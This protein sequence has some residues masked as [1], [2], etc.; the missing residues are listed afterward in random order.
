MKTIISIFTLLLLL[1][2]QGAIAQS[3]NFKDTVKLHS[4]NVWA[5]RKIE[6]IGVTRTKIDSVALHESI[7]NTLS[8]VLSQNTTI[9]IKNYGR[10]SMATASFRGTAPS[11]TQVTWNGMK[12]NSPMLGMVDFSLIPSYFVDD[13]TLL[14]G[15]GSVDVGDGALGGAIVLNNKHIKQ[16]ETIHIIQGIANYDTYDSYLRYNYGTKKLKLTTRVYNVTSVNKFPFYNM[17]KNL[18]FKTDAKGNK[19]KSVEGAPTDYNQNGKYRNTHLLQ[20]AYYKLNNN[21]HFSFVT[22]AYQS[23]RSIPTLSVNWDNDLK[24][25]TNSQ[26]D[27]NIRSVASWKWINEKFNM[28]TR[29]GY[30]YNELNYSLINKTTTGHNAAIDSK[31]SINNIYTEFNANYEITKDFK[32]TAKLNY[33]LFNVDTY[34]KQ[35]H[36]GY[37]KYRAEVSPYLALRYKAFGIWGISYNVRKTINNDVNSPLIH[38]ILTDLLIWK[39]YNLIIKSSAVKNY[40]APTLNDLYFQPGGNPDLLTEE[41]TTYDCGIEFQR[42][43]RNN[44]I[45]GSA[46]YYHSDINNWIIWTPTFKGYWVPKN[47]RKVISNGI[48]LKLTTSKKIGDF[49]LFIDA[50]WGKTISTNHG[51]KKTWGDESVGKQL[52]YIPKYSSGLMTKLTYKNYFISH[53]YHHYSER[54]TTS[55][56]DT[57]ERDK[58]EPLI[59]NDMSIGGSFYTKYG[60]FDL[61]IAINNLFNEKYQSVLKRPMPMT[62]YNILISFKL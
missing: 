4:V 26:E 9:Y 57:T 40:H 59:M 19:F 23:E 10:G 18:N 16:K 6:H 27:I 30:S 50:N 8:E 45:S 44:K 36:T 41:G 25:N 14:H 55:S 29:L 62:N 56:N 32:L 12:L 53:K 31:S 58:I 7:C 17:D 39:K 54:F 47:V 21:H 61:T 48:E 1:A 35:H 37:K 3:Y 20:E 15:A 13:M 11:H 51:D 52:V 49:K 60:Q 28:L 5:Q 34:E 42:G 24:L 38:A 43:N 2:S 33:N 22:W 46:T